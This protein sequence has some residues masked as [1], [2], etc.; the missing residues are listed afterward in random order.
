M[1]SNRN[2]RVAVIPSPLNINITLSFRWQTG[3]DVWQ[4]KDLPLRI[5]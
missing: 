5:Y 4:P 2:S 3:L 1:E